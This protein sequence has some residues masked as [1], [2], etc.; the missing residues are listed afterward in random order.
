MPR[1]M[2]P[3]DI[4]VLIPEIVTMLG[5]REKKNQI[6]QWMKVANKLDLKIER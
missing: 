5:H 3:K 4:H 6:F 2:A 1:I